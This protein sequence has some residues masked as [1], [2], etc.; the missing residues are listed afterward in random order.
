MTTPYQRVQISNETPINRRRRIALAVLYLCVMG[1]CSITL[2][3][4]GATLPQ[5]A[6]RAS[7]GKEDALDVASIYIVRGIGAVLGAACSSSIFKA[8]HG[9]HALSLSLTTLAM[10]LLL[11]PACRDMAAFHS[12][13]ILM[14]FATATLDTG[15]QIMTRKAHEGTTETGVWL[16]ANTVSFGVSGAI[17]PF[18]SLATSNRLLY[19][20]LVFV[21]FALV[22]SVALL[23]VKSPKSIEHS[24]DPVSQNDKSL[25][26]RTGGKNGSYCSPIT[27][28][29]DTGS[30]VPNDNAINN[31]RNEQESIAKNCSCRR[32]CFAYLCDP[33]FTTERL[34]GLLVFFLIGGQ[35]AMVSF[36]AIFVDDEVSESSRDTGSFVQGKGMYA[37]AGLWGAITAG[38]FVGLL[39]QIQISRDDRRKN[40]QD[41]RGDNE[42]IR[43]LF[44]DVMIFLVL[45]TIG[46]VLLFIATVQRSKSSSFKDSGGRHA[47]NS[48]SWLGTIFFGFGNINWSICKNLRPIFS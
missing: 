6:S 10:V 4:L 1:M 34:V 26:L 35:V 14:G 45:G 38:R 40:F 33:K 29:E 31:M 13:F 28:S 39:R 22:N 20:Y 23:L 47:I 27:S 24:A 48:L 43:R 17:V 21:A 19:I 46:T 42:S 3:A 7:N 30:I 18:V 44:F 11:L 2:C 37:L 25:R 41:A 36:I 9:N 16:G 15:V 5:L 32:N 8:C 12:L